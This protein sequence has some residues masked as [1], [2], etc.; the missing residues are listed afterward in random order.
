MSEVKVG[1][2][3]GGAIVPAKSGKVFERRNP[4]DARE[5]VSIAP[6]SDSADVEAAI[7]A[8]CKASL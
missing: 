1:N 3:I 8:A 7:D 2:R 5:I 4:A 6:D